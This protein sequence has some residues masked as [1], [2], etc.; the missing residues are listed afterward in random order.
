M[1][2]RVVI[3]PDSFKGTLSSRRVV[4]IISDAFAKA[5]KG[6]DIIR[7]P[8]ADGGEGSLDAII[9]VT[10]GAV[11]RAEVQGPDGKDLTARYGITPDGRAIIEMAESSGI[12]R[13]KTLHP[14]TSNTYGFGQL[15]LEALNKG[16]RKFTLCVGGSA[17]TDGGCGMAAALGA[18]FCRKNG[19]PY[20]PTGDTLSLM[21]SMDLS[22][23]DS[24]IKESEFTVM[25]DVDNPLF[26]PNGAAYIYGPQ[27][28][29]SESQVI[30]LDNGLKHLNDLLMEHGFPDFGAYP[31]AGAAGGI[32]AGCIAFLGGELKSGSEEILNLFDFENIARSADLIITGEG[33]FDSQSI[34]G[35]LIS[36]V[37]RKA[38]GTPV[39]VICGINR[40]PQEEF[41]T[42][43]L[44]VFASCDYANI[45]T[46]LKYPEKYLKMAVQE[47]I[48]YIKDNM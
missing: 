34:S 44:E 37:C 11:Y 8:I 9:S 3:A 5:F 31:G 6:M 42:R 35:K 46:S 10:G 1:I 43:I 36:G 19:K 7:M 15:I 33:S 2:K 29:A 20:V 38:S 45:K 16:A 4:E 18:K 25:C 47:C 41:E 17:T 32:G 30:M 14:T 26:G 24:R 39:I 23:M 40:C 12:T 13:Q 21:E 22:G 27:K 48:G 28:G